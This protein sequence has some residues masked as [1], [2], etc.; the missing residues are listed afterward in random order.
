MKLY[1]PESGSGSIQS[2][3]PTPS[4]TRH[5]L[6]DKAPK[7]DTGFGYSHSLFPETSKARCI[8]EIGIWHILGS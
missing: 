1:G 3:M 7:W 6:Q 4:T 5:C 8:S 2:Q